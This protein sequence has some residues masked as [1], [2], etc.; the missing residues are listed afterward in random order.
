[1]K[2]PG[3]QKSFSAAA[4]GQLPGDLKFTDYNNDG[5]VDVEDLKVIGQCIS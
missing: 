1:M 5:I 3:V 4:Y 2:E